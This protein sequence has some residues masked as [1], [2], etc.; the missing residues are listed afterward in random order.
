MRYIVAS[1]IFLI[2]IIS[3][4]FGNYFISFKNAVLNLGSDN[5]E[6]N[7]VQ[8]LLLE[9]ESLKAKILSLELKNSESIKENSIVYKPA[10]IYSTYPFNHR[11][12]FAINA[13]S[14]DGIEKSMPVAAAPGV[15]LGQIIEIFPN[16]SLVRAIFDSEFKTAVRIGLTQAD[17]LLEGGNFLTAN[18]IDKDSDI[19]PGDLVY[20]VSPEFPYGMKI[21]NI[22]KVS[23]EI[24]KNLFKKAS[25]ETAY[26]PNELKEVFVITNHKILLR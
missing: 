5:G 26:N 13:G 21:G 4:F 10:K 6:E 24:E 3:L 19:K 25:V 1:I 9:N 2:I 7:K 12:I 16:Y 11:D 8:Q 18:M 23:E 22:G 15:L 20:S 17:A 14:N